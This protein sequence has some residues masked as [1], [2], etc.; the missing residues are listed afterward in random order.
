MILVEWKGDENRPC[1]LTFHPRLTIVKVAQATQDR[2]VEEIAAALREQ[3][4][5]EDSDVTVEATFRDENVLDAS[6]ATWLLAPPSEDLD[7]DADQPWKRLA[8]AASCDV[9]AV[10]N[11]ILELELEINELERSSIIDEDAARIAE[12]TAEE[13]VFESLLEQASSHDEEPQFPPNAVQNLGRLLEILHWRIELLKTSLARE[14]ADPGEVAEQLAAGNNDAIWALCE[15]WEQN[16]LR[17]EALIEEDRATHNQARPPSWLVEQSRVEFEEASASLAVF[18]VLDDV[19]HEPNVMELAVRRRH[20]E[21]AAVWGEL[22]PYLD[23]RHIQRE[24]EM[25][26][27]VIAA[28]DF[29]GEMPIDANEAVRLISNKLQQL[30]RVQEVSSVRDGLVGAL[31]RAGTYVAED[32]IVIEVAT[33][34]VQNRKAELAQQVWQKEELAVL[35]EDRRRVQDYL[36]LARNAL[37]ENGSPTEEAGIPTQELC[38]RRKALLEVELEQARTRASYFANQAATV[39]VH[40]E[41]GSQGEAVANALG[42]LQTRVQFDSTRAVVTNRLEKRATSVRTAA[43]GELIPFVLDSAVDNLNEEERSVL[44]DS[45]VDVSA[46]CQIICFTQDEAVMDW[47]WAQSADVVTV[48]EDVTE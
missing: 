38:Q 35:Q 23:E 31:R 6:D 26:A 15:E 7:G 33:T 40:G 20:A 41:S 47:A 17:L 9:E 10:E 22:L 45:L 29:V 14:I 27:L 34:W 19:D 24:T 18:S 46:G 3:P 43:K 32:D 30:Q 48:N 25:G 44:L 28:S 39:A 16:R 8:K 36:V 37:G 4:P 42:D 2:L 5:F 13:A 12:A 11:R 21:A 1:R